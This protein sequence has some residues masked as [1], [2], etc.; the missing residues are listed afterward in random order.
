M[1]S[2]QRMVVAVVLAQG[3]AFS[4]AL[5]RADDDSTKR[6]DWRPPVKAKA[7][8]GRPVHADEWKLGGA[9]DEGGGVAGG[10]AAK[11]ITLQSWLPLNELPGNGDSGADC[12]GYT[13]PSGREYA[14]ECVSQGTCFVEVTDPVLYEEYRKGAPGEI[15]LQWALGSAASAN[16]KVGWLWLQSSRL[17]AMSERMV[18]SSSLPAQSNSRSRSKEV[19]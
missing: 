19:S 5:V 4:A 17:S 10:F 7:I 6:R 12:W 2:R 9:S 14:I 18:A 11:G 3:L 13:S 15:A 1:P 8:T 16:A